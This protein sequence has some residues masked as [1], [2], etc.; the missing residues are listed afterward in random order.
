MLIK[1][2]EK[3]QE[4]W[5]K[6]YK[7]YPTKNKIK[8]SRTYLYF[9]DK[10][11]LKCDQGNTSLFLRGKAINQSHICKTKEKKDSMKL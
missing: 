6:S 4:E 11:R 9:I 5:I 1:K 8:M 10:W 2:D 3:D 7:L